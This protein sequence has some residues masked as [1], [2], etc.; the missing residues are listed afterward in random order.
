MVGHEPSLANGG[1]E[2]STGMGPRG[3]HT[4]DDSI[5][6]FHSWQPIGMT[7]LGPS[8]Q[9]PSVQVMETRNQKVDSSA[10]KHPARVAPSAVRPLR[11]RLR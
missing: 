8:E 3:N 1:R 5:T 4:Q 2:S 7:R 9:T 11:L 10:H 6:L